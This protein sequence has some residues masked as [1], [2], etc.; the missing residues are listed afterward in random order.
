MRARKVVMI[1]STVMDL[2]LHRDEIRDACDRA[3]FE[4]HMME[5]LPALAADAPKASLR[6]VDDAD[7]YVGIFANRYG[8]V[9]AGH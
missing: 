2:P 9:P 1:S 4:P 7:V 5:K 3:D 6:M 8:Y